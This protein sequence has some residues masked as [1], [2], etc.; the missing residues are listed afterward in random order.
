MKRF[1]SI[2]E[3]LS[4]NDILQLDGAFSALHINYGKSPLFNGENSKDL[5]KNSRKN[6][7]SSLEHVEDVFEYMTHFNGVEND[8]KKADRI[9]LWEKYWLEYT[10]AFEHLTEVLPKSVTT[11]YMG[12]Q[13]IELGFKY[14]LLRKDVSDK[15]LR[16]HNLKE[17]ADLMWVKYSI[18]EPYMGEIP[19]FCNCYS[20]MLEGDNVEY[21]RY[22]EYSRKR[23]FA[24]NRLDIEWLSYNFALILLKVLQF[25][26]LTL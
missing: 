7:V 12:R 6:S 9:V 14:L 15:E 5:A 4:Y 10:N 19:D 1:Q 2:S 25:A 20:K 22:P 23:Y 8:F 21:F 26:N 18:E 13:A 3:N 24:G 17:L 16:T 11:A